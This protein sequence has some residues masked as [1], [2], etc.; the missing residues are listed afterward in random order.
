LLIAKAL[1]DGFTGRFLPHNPRTIEDVLDAV[2]LFGRHLGRDQ[3][4]QN[5]VVA[6]RE[7]LDRAAEYVN[8][9]EDGPSVAILESVDPLRIAG[10]WSVQLV[11]RAGGRYPLNQTNPKPNAGAAAG[12][13]QAE[14]IAGPPVTVPAELFA[15]TAPDRLIIATGDLDHCRAS[16][17]SLSQRAWFADLPG[18]RDGQIALI[19]AVLFSI[20]GP[21]IVDTFEF[22]VGWLQ[23]RDSLIPSGFSWEPFAPGSG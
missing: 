19:D 15:A 4:A 5:L 10:H 13:Q 20:P 3:S 16:A 9:Y 7:R 8:A 21:A 14:R 18:V 1:P 2:L 11:E 17:R 6:M 22:L 23:G 12:P